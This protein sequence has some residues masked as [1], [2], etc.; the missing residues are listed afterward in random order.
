MDQ[1]M[2]LA[3]L[4][5]EI[6]QKDE[7]LKRVEIEIETTKKIIAMFENI[8]NKADAIS[9]KVKEMKEGVKDNG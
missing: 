8:E 6:A 2:E 3:R 5:M 9:D 4:Q 7:E 1:L